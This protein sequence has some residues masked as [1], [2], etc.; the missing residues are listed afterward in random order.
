VLF[1]KELSIVHQSFCI[2]RIVG[3]NKGGIKG[4]GTKFLRFSGMLGQKAFVT[5][6][7][8]L[9][10]RTN[11]GVGLCSVRGLLSLAKDVPLRNAWAHT[12][13]VEKYGVQASD[14]W[15]KDAQA[16]LKKAEPIAK[17]C[18]S[19]TSKIRNTRVAHL[20]QPGP[21]ADPALLPGLDASERI[22]ELAYDFYLFIACGFLHSM[23]AERN[24]EAGQS[25]MELLKQRFD[26]SSAQYDLPHATADAST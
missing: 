3:V 17:A 7:E 14:D 21:D 13:F 4:P 6:I 9:F 10:E 23:G 24:D 22:I 26:L 5:G 19:L 12:R 25:L 15:M 1:V 8:S 20:E 11:N 16:V 18:L 2:Y